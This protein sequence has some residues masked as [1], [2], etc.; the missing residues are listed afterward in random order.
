M[1]RIA[2]TYQARRQAHDAINLRLPEVSVRVQ[3]DGMVAIRPIRPL[4]SRALVREAMLMAGEAAA[5]FALARD[6]PIPFATQAP[7]NVEERPA[8][9]DMAGMYA[10]RRHLKRSA[11]SVEPSP[12]AGLGLALYTRVTSP[13]RRYMD[14]VIHQQ[15][16]AYL[17]HEEPLNRQAVIERIGAVEAVEDS[18]R[19]AE[20][21]SCE[22][23]TLVYLLQHPEWRGEGILVDKY[24]GRGVALI[25][26]LDLE[27]RIHLPGDLPLNSAV[28]L[29]ATEVNLPE[30]R[31]YFQM[32]N[33]E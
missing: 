25:P 31:A 19:R 26:T 32:T 9:D 15:L 6:I 10:L 28:S 14:L 12:H 18:V 17:R 4:R 16:R 2:Q 3:A 29:T 5:R 20:R 13:L 22:H 23:W 33:S 1:Y 21:L 27:A 7:P 30:L 11:Y 8:D 24:H